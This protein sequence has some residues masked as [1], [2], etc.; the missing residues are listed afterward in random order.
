MYLN[1]NLPIYLM[2]RYGHRQLE[3]EILS[4]RE[5]DPTN[6]LFK[7]IKSSFYL[8]FYLLFSMTTFSVCSYNSHGLGTGRLAYID[9]LI[10][11]HDFVFIQETWLCEDRLDI[12]SNNI[13]NVLSHGVSGMDSNQPLIGRPYGGCSIIWKRD[14]AGTITPIETISKRIC[15]IMY[16]FNNVNILLINVYMPYDSNIQVDNL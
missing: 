11:A 16:C 13:N 8:Y 7:F 12:F 3:W 4:R 6:N 5:A 15:C 1:R 9:S 2:A 10:S 14:I